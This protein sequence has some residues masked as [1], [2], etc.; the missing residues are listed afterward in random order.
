MTLSDRVVIVA[1]E[2]SGTER[3]IQG[4]LQALSNL[5]RNL[6]PEETRQLNTLRAGVLKLQDTLADLYPNVDHHP[7]I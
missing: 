5:G 7:H 1:Q 2:L 3:D 6:S 4:L